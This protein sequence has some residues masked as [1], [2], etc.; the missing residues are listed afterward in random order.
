MHLDYIKSNHYLIAE[1]GLEALADLGYW[2]H[3]LECGKI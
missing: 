2:G 3:T 1:A